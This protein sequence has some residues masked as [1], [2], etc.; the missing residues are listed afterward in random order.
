MDTQNLKEAVREFLNTHRKA[1]F[2]TVDDRA[3]PHT[4]FM[5]Y[6]IDDDFNVYF[7]T[8]KSYKKYE[9]I[10]SNPSVSLS[11]IEEG[12]DPLRV[13]D[14]RGKAEIIPE[15]EQEKWFD[16]LKTKNPSKYYVE[17]ADDFV[18]LRVKPTLVRVLDARSGE[19]TITNLDI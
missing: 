11:V 7:G 3:Q 19:L 18:M 17:G 6:A 1:V 13:V 10:R 12:L 9:Q 15:N 2:A 4:S 16:F 5:L 14:L 8:R